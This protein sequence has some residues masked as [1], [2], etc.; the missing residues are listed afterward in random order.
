MLFPFL[1]NRSW[2]PNADSG[3]ETQIWGTLTATGLNAPLGGTYRIRFYPTLE[4]YNGKVQPINENQVTTAIYQLPPQQRHIPFMLDNVKKPEPVLT[5]VDKIPASRPPGTGHG[6]TPYFSPS[7]RIDNDDP[8]ASPQEGGMAMMMNHG[9][10]QSTT[11]T[12]VATPAVCDVVQGEEEQWDVPGCHHLRFPSGHRH[13]SSAQ[14][15]YFLQQQIRQIHHANANN[16]NVPSQ[17]NNNHD[18]HHHYHHHHAADAVQM[19]HMLPPFPLA[20]SSDPCMELSSIGYPHS[21]INGGGNVHPS[22]HATSY[23]V[24]SQSTALPCD[25][26]HITNLNTMP[27]FD[28]HY[29]HPS[30]SNNNISNPYA[31]KYAPLALNMR[32]PPYNPLVGCPYFAPMP[33]PESAYQCSTTAEEHEEDEEQKEKVDVNFPKMSSVVSSSKH[34]SLPNHSST[35]YSSSNCCSP[36]AAANITLRELGLHTVAQSRRFPS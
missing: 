17:N 19:Q 10:S 18:A 31:Q 6:F 29:H 25:S 23:V 8:L 30:V 26:S 14:Q 12:T 4:G 20:S 28:S 24:Q 5:A 9:G 27:L 7:V 15:A 11:T 22:V 35:S 1:L 16:H 36:I 13:P 32:D 21:R 33:Q 34:N 3:K 2:S